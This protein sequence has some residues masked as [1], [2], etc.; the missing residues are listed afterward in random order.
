[1]SA[2]IDFQA[3]LPSKP[4]VSSNLQRLTIRPRKIA[5]NYEYIQ[6]NDPFNL[7][8]LIFDI[9]RGIESFYAFEEANLP[10]P[11]IISQNKENGNC[12]IFYMLKNAVWTKG[13]GRKKPENYVNAIKNGYT[14]KLQA[15][16]AYSGLISKNP[17]HSR[18]RN[19]DLNKKG[20]ELDE[21]AENIDL[22]ITTLDKAIK[23]AEKR[24]EEVLSNGRNDELFNTLRFYSYE[25]L[26]RYKGLAK[27]IS[28][29]KVYSMWLNAIESEANA[30]NREFNEQLSSNE[31]RQIAKS[32]A[33]WSWINYK[34]KEKYNRGRMGFGETRHENKEIPMLSEDEKKERQKQAAELTNKHRKEK[35][36]LAIKQATELIEKNGNKATQKRVSEKS[37]ICLRTVKIHWKMRK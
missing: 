32:V 28:S 21:L 16:N 36:I 33:K 34:P 29:D 37:G 30:L 20:Y 25:R 7:K 35:T 31:V 13:T 6:P 11:N 10:E 19:T 26:D 1:M 24:S 12:H 23:N 17:I 9:D 2:F 27:E 22:S 18:W 3:N 8:W 14:Q 4:Y 5:I 15:D